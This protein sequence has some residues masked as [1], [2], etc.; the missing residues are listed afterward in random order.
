MFEF[1]I[2]FFIAIP[3]VF[4]ISTQIF[5]WYANL[6]PQYIC[7]AIGL[8]SLSHL[9]FHAGMAFHTKKYAGVMTSTNRINLDY[10]DI[11]FY[12]KWAW[13]F[14]IVAMVLAVAAGPSNLFVGRFQIE[15]VP[16][17]GLT[18]QFLF[19]CRSLSLL[20]MIMLLFLVKY[21]P[22]SKIK[23][24][25]I[26]FLAMFLLPFIAINYLPALPRFVLF[27]IFI[28]LS[29]FVI[30]Y[31]NTKNKA[32]VAIFSIVVLFIVFP[33]IKSLGREELDLSGALLRADSSVISSYLLRVDF[34]AFMQIVSTVE[35]YIKDIGPIRY[36]VNFIG[37]ILFFVPRALWANKPLDTG[38]IVSADLGYFYNNVSSPLQ[39][40]ALMGFGFIGPFVIFF[41]LAFY[42]SRIE[43]HAK[44]LNNCIPL[45]SSFF[46]YAIL[47]GFI[48]IVMRGALNAVAAQFCT[49]FIALYLM[50]F[51]KSNIRFNKIKQLSNFNV[52]KGN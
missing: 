44:S 6:H 1:F 32:S 42:I 12:S 26:Y 10:R 33:G 45:P 4:Q 48:A 43:F 40:E 29:T 31:F 23:I 7:L 41:L 46:I 34:D 30:D 50:Q 16:F 36:G 17:E 9:A 22:N 28:A 2:L 51:V 35:Y 24:Q 18:Q 8:I 27:G 25:N 21:S 52:S 14:A 11:L 49:A 3:A 15:R 19:M 39:A 37:V 47:M 38:Q 13:S 5:P 20:S